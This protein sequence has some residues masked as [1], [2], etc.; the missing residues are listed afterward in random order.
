MS[1]P[2]RILMVEDVPTDAALVEREIRKAGIDF[3]SR[4]VENRETF[5]AAIEEFDPDFILSDYSLPQFDGM[6]ALRLAD[7]RA[8]EIPF[9]I[10]TGSLNEETAVECIKAGADDYVLKDRLARLMPAIQGALEK[11]RLQ[12]ERH[13]AVVA[14]RTSEMRYRRL[15]EAAKDGILILDAETGL[16]VD[17]NPFIL[18][19]LGYSAQEVLG[20]S[21]WDLGFLRDVVP[22]KAAFA[23]L[24]EKKYVRYEDMPL[25]AK[26]GSRREVEFVSNVYAVGDRQVIQCNI[27][28]ITERKR[29]E[30]ALRET[31]ER[32]RLLVERNLAGVF[33]STIEGRVL[34]CNEAFAA[35]FGYSSREDL[36]AHPSQ[37]L[38]PTP[39]ARDIFVERIRREGAVKNL[40]SEGRRKDGSPVWILENVSLV[41][42]EKTGQEV[43]E[44]TAIDITEQRRAEEERGRL[45][46]AIEQSHE[47]IVMTDAQ[48]AIIYVNPAFES[49]TGYSREE[50]MGQ[51]PRI[52]KSGLHDRAFYE[53]MWATILSGRAWTGQMNNLRKDGSL[54]T[55]QSVIS[56]VRDPSGAITA[57]VAAKR[58]VTQEIELQRKLEQAKN[59]ET[60][61]MI[62]G[63]VAHEVRNP[64]FAITTIVTALERKLADQPE[65]AEYTAHIK[66]Q[67]KRLNVLM[68]DLLTLGRPIDPQEFAALDLRDVLSETKALVKAGGMDTTPCLMEL[69]GDPLPILGNS[70][71]LQQAFANLGQNALSFTPR[72]GLVRVRAW[73]ERNRACVE[74]SDMGPGIPTDL[75]PVLFAPF[76]TRRKGGTG[77][78]LA[79]VRQIVT[80]HGGTVEAANNQPPPGATF[81]VRLPLAEVSKGT[82]PGG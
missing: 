42:E 8:P 82:G 19:I 28:D 20:K 5:L 16:V 67:S 18:N 1:Q 13:E 50:A 61:G 9:I 32:Y 23:E 6:S 4:R 80:A 10:I 74:I 21:I 41:R 33:R 25:E 44:G 57:F 79:I 22:S 46:A 48:G 66:D 59:L 34:D 69:D 75:F 40:V 72:G 35:I 31:Q 26:D 60:V 24:L 58:D 64:L 56:P 47:S 7:E 49:I 53:Q 45:A 14:M 73:R 11:R 54:F 77:L 51:N 63:G 29:A 65:F 3:V 27:R 17:V 12:G 38:Y 52:L 78:G 76:Q 15:F 68:N 55:E 81:T 30:K 43:L 62:A 37:G 2:L 71:K 39:E 36:F 70:Q